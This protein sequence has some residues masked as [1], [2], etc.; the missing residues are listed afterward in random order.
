MDNISVARVLHVLSII[1]WIG[2]GIRNANRSPDVPITRNG[3][4]SLVSFREYRAAFFATG[5]HLEPACGRNRSLDDLQDGHLGSIC[6]SGV[7]VD[8][9]DVRTVAGIH[10]HGL[11]G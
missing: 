10:A 2:V 3:R 6:R 7:L 4:A 5:S 8:D 11:R 1:H 9:G